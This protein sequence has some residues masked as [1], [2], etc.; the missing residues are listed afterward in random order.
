MLVPCPRAGHRGLTCARSGRPPVATVSP[1]R[2]GNHGTRRDEPAR[3]GRLSALDSVGRPEPRVAGGSSASSATSPGPARGRPR[4]QSRRSPCSATST[5]TSGRPPC[6][7]RWRSTPSPPSATS[8]CSCPTTSKGRRRRVHPL[9]QQE[10][11]SGGSALGPIGAGHQGAGVQPVRKR[12]SLESL[13]A[14][15]DAAWFDRRSAVRRRRW[16]LAFISQ[17][18]SAD[19]SRSS[20]GGGEGNRTPVQGFAGPCLSHSA[21]PPGNGRR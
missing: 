7:T 3:R 21:T 12:Q 17:R 10:G 14:N 15:T 8:T 16:Q 11:L 1:R 2:K 5:S 19:V 13:S 4:R 6:R 20:L 18:N 9:R